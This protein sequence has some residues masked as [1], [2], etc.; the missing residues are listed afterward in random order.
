MARLVPI[1]TR[2]RDRRLSLGLRQASVA[3]TA[4]V[5][6]SYLNLIEHDRR[7]SRGRF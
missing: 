7:P 2:I 5:S 6:A 3:E 4:G 1:G